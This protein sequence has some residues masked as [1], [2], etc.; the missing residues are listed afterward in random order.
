MEAK[1][2]ALLKSIAS[3]K[4]ID[5]VSARID[6]AINSFPLNSAVVTD[7]NEFMHILANFYCLVESR[8]LGLHQDRKP[9]F[10]FDWGRCCN[11]LLKHWGL[12]G[13]KAAFEMA[14][15]G[16][17]G[18]LK[19][20]LET[21]ASLMSQQYAEN[22]IT[23]RSLHFWNPLTTDEKFTVMDIYLKKYGHLLPSELTESNAIRLRT[24][25]HTV[26][27]QHPYM[28]KK[29]GSIGK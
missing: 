19:R 5:Q 2:D 9:N 27:K 8:A 12:S 25:F 7:W 10:D 15:T 3:E 13:E 24:K 23:S 6:T 26:F 29:L 18:G 22:E 17:E 20:V 1:L 4:T 21:I 16:N 14:R 11:L 28:M